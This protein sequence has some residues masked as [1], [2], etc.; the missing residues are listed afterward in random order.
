VTYDYIKGLLENVKKSILENGTIA[1]SCAPMISAMMSSLSF[2]VKSGS[3]KLLVDMTK[4]ICVSTYQNLIH[5][6]A[7]LLAFGVA[8]VCRSKGVTV[9]ASEWFVAK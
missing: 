1:W 2:M 4:E 5:L 9:T 3:T 7:I 8:V 6:D